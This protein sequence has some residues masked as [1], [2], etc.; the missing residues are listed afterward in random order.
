MSIIIAGVALTML[1]QAFVIGGVAMLGAFALPPIF[2]FA[3]K[4]VSSGFKLPEVLN[5]SKGKPVES[6][7]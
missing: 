7:S 1:Q 2:R 5:R 6:Q 3:K 4:T